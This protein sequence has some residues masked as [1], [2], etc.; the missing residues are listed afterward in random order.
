MI[1]SAKWL[2]RI[3]NFLVF[4][5]KKIKILIFWKYI[6]AKSIFWR[7][8]KNR[9]YSIEPYTNN[10]FTKFQANIFISG[11]AMFKKHVNVM[12]SLYLTTIFSI[13]NCRTSKQMTFLESWDKTGQHRYV[14]K[15]IVW[16]SKLK[17]LTWTW[18]DLESGMK[19]SVAFGFYVPNDQ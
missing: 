15:R 2:S 16:V 18:T 13:S 14:F 7:Y 1:R 4:D 6:S 11:C 9:M 8:P 17:F 5:P 3:F 10:Q 12:T 19:M